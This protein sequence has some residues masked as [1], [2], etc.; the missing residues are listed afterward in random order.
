MR[1]KIVKRIRRHKRIRKR[2]LG[3]ATRPRLCVYRSLG[4]F[5]AQLIDD[6]HEKT[7]LYLSTLNKEV[8]KKVA[9]GGNTKAAELLGQLLAEQAKSKGISKVVLDRGGFLYHGRV[10]ALAES[11]R[12]N[13]LEF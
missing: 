6:L 13:G 7:L 11:C 3:T 2:I 4:N 10:K 9:Y 1:D 5:H 12:K 8:K